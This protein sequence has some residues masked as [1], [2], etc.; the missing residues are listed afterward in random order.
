MNLRKLYS[1]LSNPGSFSGVNKFWKY[2]K[3]TYPTLT[4]AEVVKFLRTSDTYT[5]HF[6]KRKIKRFRRIFV[7][8]IGYQYNMDLVDL[9]KYSRQNAGYKYILNI[10]GLLYIYIY[11]YI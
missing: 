6:P 10:I 3:Q 7:K 4:K 1:D 8:G 9:Q 2:A 11:I 5:L